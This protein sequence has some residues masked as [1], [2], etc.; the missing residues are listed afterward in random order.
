[1]PVQTMVVDNNNDSTTV[2]LM[3]V[4]KNAQV[5]KDDFKLDLGSDVK[6]LRG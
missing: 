1:L 6:K 2:R 3:N 5:N 4:E